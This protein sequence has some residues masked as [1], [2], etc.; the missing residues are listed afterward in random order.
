MQWSDEESNAQFGNSI[1]DECETINMTTE[2]DIDTVPI[3]GNDSS[4][5]VSKR[6]RRTFITSR[7][8]SAL[9]NA[10]VSDGMAVH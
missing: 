3:E 1:D 9:D 4:K 6:G 10:K 2:P 8:A 7:L 5:A